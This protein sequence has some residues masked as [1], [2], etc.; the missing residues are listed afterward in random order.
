[1]ISKCVQSVL[2]STPLLSKFF[3]KIRITLLSS[4]EN[5]LTHKKT[6]KTSFTF[7]L[8]SVRLSI[9]T[10]SYTDF[11][12]TPLAVHFIPVGRSVICSVVVLEKQIFSSF[13]SI[14]ESL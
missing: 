12:A 11:L 9:K 2:T 13:Q 5:Q 4:D 1:M 6:Q 10:T 14:S 7:F 3:S 8:E